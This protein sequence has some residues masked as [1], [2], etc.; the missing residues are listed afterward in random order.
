MGF[1]RKLPHHL[2]EAFKSTLEEARYSD[3]ILHVVDVSNPQM[4]TQIHIVYE[5]LR[6]L[7]ITDKTV[8]TVF[9]KMDRLTGDVILRDFRSDFQV[10]ISAKT[11]EGIPALLETLEG[12]L[13]SLKVYLEKVFPYAQAGKIQSI[14]RYGELLSE[15][16]TEEGIAVKAY[17]PAEIYGSIL[18]G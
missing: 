18:Q 15:E 5:T 12:I 8:I 10:K 2:I 6:Q 17:V 1:I 11:G 4:E 14:R 7:E 9:N 16:Y 13:R 3:I